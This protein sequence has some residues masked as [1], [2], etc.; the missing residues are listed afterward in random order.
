ME[1]D[2]NYISDLN[3]KTTYI[4]FKKKFP[5]YSRKTNFT[6]RFTIIHLDL[7]SKSS[8]LAISTHMCQIT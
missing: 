4:K 5:I 7:S 2:L 3:F 6:K 1:S 8:V